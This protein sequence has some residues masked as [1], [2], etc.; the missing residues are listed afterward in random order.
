MSQAENAER[1][2]DL[3]LVTGAGASREF[4][5]GG[6]K[7]PL[8]PDWS[9]ALVQKLSTSGM[10]HLD[11]VGLTREMSG[12]QF[13]E[14]LGQFLRQSQALDDIEDLLEPS[15]RLMGMPNEIQTQGILK[16]WHYQLQNHVDQ[17]MG[18]IHNSLFEMFSQTDIDTRRAV[19]EFRWLL[20]VL[21][22]TTTSPFVFATTNYD[23]IA[24]RV[25]SEL[26]RLPDWGAPPKLYPGA[27]E[28]VLKVDDLLGGMNRY[29]PVLHLHGKA[30]WYEKDERVIEIAHNE[31]SKDF[32]IPVV[33]LPDLA[34][35]YGASAVINSIW[36]QFRAALRRAQRVLVLGHSL[37]DRELLEALRANVQPMSR[38][39]VSVY[40]AGNQS[41]SVTADPVKAIVR[42]YLPG[43][44]VIEMQFGQSHNGE[45]ELQQWL[46]G[47]S[48]TR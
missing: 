12:E 10:G 3:V 44:T 21:Q 37:H 15:Q 48:S 36:S 32:G 22:V 40:V 7:L 38:I 6:A 30:G 25:V 41:P 2:I 14:R 39:A 13:E 28:N 16:S 29:T 4:G 9:N 45:A 31:Y 47:T 18:A 5:I 43:A 19:E 34:K 42:D 33:M 17:I 24:S 46:T 27:G 8:M 11:L 20:G 26:G 1:D 35:D 23:I